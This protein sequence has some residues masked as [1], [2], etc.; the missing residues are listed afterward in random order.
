MKK[1]KKIVLFVGSVALLAVVAAV[2][3]IVL[4]GGHRVIKV[5]EFE[6]DVT[7]E[8]NSEEKD[9]VE[10]MNLK[11]E[12]SITTGDDGLVELLVDTDKHILAQENTSFVIISKGNEKKGK[13]VIK[14]NYGTS[15]VEIENK[16]NDK[17]FECKRY[18]F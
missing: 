4:G 2:L 5:D 14:L 16:L 11:S 1:G 3:F 7:F 10:G 8:R 15:L 9:I 13:L 6:G 12:D 18:Y 17:S